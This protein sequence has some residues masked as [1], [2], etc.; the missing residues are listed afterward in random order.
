M[1][2]AR[3]LKTRFWRCLW[4]AP[5]AVV[6][7]LSSGAVF[8]QDPVSATNDREQSLTE[9]WTQDRMD[10]AVPMDM[11]VDAGCVGS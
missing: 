4:L 6:F 8:A 2:H 10:N 9:Y 1:K 11:E 5:L 3:N 7:I